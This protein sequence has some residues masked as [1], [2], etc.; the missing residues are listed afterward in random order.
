MRN[1][2]FASLFVVVALIFGVTNSASADQWDYIYG[3]DPTN[4]N[5]VSVFTEVRT[6]PL[7]GIYLLGYFYGQYEGLSSPSQF[8]RFAQHRS[9]AGTV[10]W[11]IPLPNNPQ[12]LGGGPPEMP[13]DIVVDGQGVAFISESRI[14]Q[15]GW[16]S[17]DRRGIVSIES[18]RQSSYIPGTGLFSGDL[19][20][21]CNRGGIALSQGG[22]AR[23]CPNETVELVDST[24][25]PIWSS[26][27]S[28]HISTF[29]SL[30]VNTRIVAGPNN[31][32]WFLSNLN[33]A[34]VNQEQT[35]LPVSLRSALS[36][37]QLDGETG[38]QLKNIKHP[39]MIFGKP[40]PGP[41]P[42]VAQ[43]NNDRTLWIETLPVP[44]T[45]Q[46]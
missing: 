38:F 6:D 1:R 2:F 45:E 3:E 15:K 43:N 12:L 33:A 32:V 16:F 4:A 44:A 31:S 17:I 20:S 23:L 29:Y 19:D 10:D 27:V 42:F 13:F 14:Y 21:L 11:T 5:N 24:F 22:L 36:M 40:G 39:G 34:N 30:D 25:Q 37:T 18:D 26:D 41:I 7:G 9:A 35:Q 46:F 28:A 8:L